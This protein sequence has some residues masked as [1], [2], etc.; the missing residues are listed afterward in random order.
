MHS[1]LVLA[2]L[3]ASGSSLAA[4]LPIGSSGDY[5]T[6]NTG[7]HA[8]T[9]PAVNYSAS[10]KHFACG[11]NISHASSHFLNHIHDLHRADLLNWPGEGSGPS[12]KLNARAVSTITLPLYMHVVTTPANKNMIKA[13]QMTQQLNQ[14]NADYK[15]IGV[16]FKLMNTSWTVNSAWA[17]GASDSDDANMKQA[18]R[19]GTYGSLNL[20]FQSDLAGGVL[21]KCTLPTSLGSNPT[22]STYNTDGCNIALGTVPNG[23]IM[24]YNMGKTAVHETGHWLGLLHTFEGYSC[25]GNGDFVADTPAESQSTDGCPTSPWKNTCKSRVGVDPIHN[26]MDYSTDACYERFTAGQQ[27]RIHSL[28]GQYRQGQ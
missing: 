18:L 9:G 11:T 21:G 4:V 22:P 8:L 19:Q 3:A 6:Q 25:S 12:Q 15:P 2:A 5:F 14:M 17:I 13:S 7:A 27:G 16:Q 28:W 10:I 23:P 26:Y 20:Y 24:G 1:S